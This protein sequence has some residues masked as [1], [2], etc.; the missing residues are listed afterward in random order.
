MKTAYQ[1]VQESRERRKKE[2]VTRCEVYAPTKD[3]QKIKDLASK[4]MESF[5][6]KKPT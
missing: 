3:H 4:L 1:R 5:A 6:R 2:G